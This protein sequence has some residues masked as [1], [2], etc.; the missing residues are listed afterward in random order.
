MGGSRV[1]ERIQ[2]HLDS[3]NLP[4][5]GKISQAAVPVAAAATRPDQAAAMPMLGICCIGG[6]WQRVDES[7]SS[8]RRT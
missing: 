3:A 1:D 6:E 5:R 4:N 2:L 8:G 7:Q